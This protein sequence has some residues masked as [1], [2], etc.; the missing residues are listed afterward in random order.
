M[1]TAPPGAGRGTGARGGGAVAQRF[2]YKD[3][4]DIRKQPREPDK[5]DGQRIAWATSLWDA[6]DEL[7]RIRDRMIEENLRM[8]A[9]QQWTVYNNRIGRFVDVTRW[10]TDE[11]K[12]WR[13]RPV[14]NRL[15]LWFM[16]THARMNENPPIITFL[17]GPD[18]IDAEAAIT[19]DIIWKAKWRE[20][21]LTAIW[22]RASAW[23]VP[24]G[25]VYLR[26]RIDPEKGKLV[27]R[28]GRSQLPMMGPEGPMMDGEEPMVTEEEFDDVP[29]GEDFEPLMEMTPDGTRTKGQPFVERKGDLNVDVFNALQVR[30]E[31]SPRPWH[32]K[33]WHQIRTFLT[34][35]EIMHTWGVDT[36]GEAETAADSTG[37]LERILFGKGFFGAADAFFGS[38]FAGASMPEQLVE[39]FEL[40]HRPIMLPSAP[41]M[42]ESVEGPGGRVLVCTRNKVLNDDVR[43]FPF[44]YTSGLRRFE[45][46]NVPG[47]P[48]GGTTPQ[49]AMNGAQ[50][51]YNR[52]W[53]QILEHRNLVTNPKGIIDSMSGLE[54]NDVDNEPGTWHVVTRRPNVPAMEYVAPPP[55]G[56]DVYQ[57]QALLLNEITDLGALSGTEGDAPTEDASGE[58]VKELRFNADRFVGPT[59]RRAVEEFG[60][61]AEDWQ[62]MLPFVFDE[63]ELF[64]YAGEDNTART[65][66]I[67]PTLFTEGKV[68]VQPDIESMLPEGRGERQQRIAALYANGLFGQPGS[69]EAIKRFFDLSSFPHL[70]RARKF[71]GVHRITAEQENGQILQGM[72]VRQIP[73]F[74]WYDDAIHLMVHEDFMASPEYLKQE[75]PIRK[76]FEFHRGMHII[77]IQLKAAQM[78]PPNAPSPSPSGTQ[79]GQPGASS[80]AGGP[81]GSMERGPRGQAEVPTGAGQGGAAQFGSFGG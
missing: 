37:A 79:R 23:L 42:R 14:F 11:E 63:E 19:N 10:M 15:L 76:A 13:Q 50:R 45:F 53:A 77:N 9:G 57:T 51:A 24:S 31:W 17:P 71:G 6:Q 16:I 75:E 60:R 35:Q 44:K 80:G 26:S 47:R 49:E 33:R 81:S 39:V 64:S 1:P 4:P 12:R 8:L 40:W 41:R 46:V 66:L 7:L 48:G 68:N 52:G 70:D 21:G 18:R 38:D 67:L 59:M 55:L 56:Q 30:G 74:E 72:D 69:P 54:E 65:I 61:L 73:V 34:P 3:I 28:Q 29:F 32:E 43:P 25:T 27:P 58:L 36:I 2:S 78:M 22:D 5:D 62:A 20:I